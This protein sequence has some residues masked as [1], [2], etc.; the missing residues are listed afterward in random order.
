MCVYVFVRMCGVNL[1]LN[2]WHDLRG[3]GLGWWWWCCC[4]RVRVVGGRSRNLIR[5][6]KRAHRALDSGQ[7]VEA[8]CESSRRNGLASANGRGSSS[9]SR[10]KLCRV[11][12]GRASCSVAIVLLLLGL[13]RRT[14][15]GR[16]RTTFGVVLV[17]RLVSTSRTARLRLLQT[18]LALV[19]L[20]LVETR[21]LVTVEGLRGAAHHLV[22]DVLVLV[23][24]HVLRL[25]SHL[26]VRFV[27]LLLL[28]TRLWVLSLV[29]LLL[30][31]VAST[32]VLVPAVS[33]TVA[34]T[35]TSKLVRSIRS[36]AESVS[37][38]ASGWSSE[39]VLKWL[40]L[41]ATSPRSTESTLVH[42]TVS[43]RC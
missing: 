32:A 3:L 39:A 29:R 19:R 36:T 4:S 41:E 43:A 17:V 8:G 11:C 35:G 2:W 15:S 10:R 27:Q 38:H 34:T 6:G 7:R 12:R 33:S 37:S 1:L 20:T 16:F 23:L 13:I 24:V 5:R 18:T 21:A 9:C 22:R 31:L 30:L 26:L 25:I 40:L 42:A 14:S 28:S